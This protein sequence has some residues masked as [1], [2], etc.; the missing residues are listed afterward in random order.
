MHSSEHDAPGI[1][2][3]LSREEVVPFLRVPVDDRR[4]TPIEFP[5]PWPDRPWTF[6]VMVASSNGVVAWRRRGAR[7]DPVRTILG[8]ED[9]PERIA[10]RRLM[11]LLRS[12]GDVAIGAE[13]V[14]EEP[15]LVPT[16]QE[17]GDEPAPELYRFR[18]SRG[19]SYHPRTILYSLYGRLPIAHP[20]FHTPGLQ[21]IVVT[22][23]AGARELA[24]RGVSATPAKLLVEALPD[25]AALARVHRRLH[26][27]LGVRYLACEGGQT[28]LHALHDARL[29]D[30]VFL[31]VTDVVIDD[32]AHED[33]VKIFDFERERAELVAEGRIA[34][35]SRYTFQRWR[36]R[37]R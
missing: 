6:G 27:E 11:R 3:R 4:T 7:D 1:E 18:T 16:P 30:E 13:T 35:D 17:P 29:L 28:V 34:P 15:K 22:T 21:P 31:T 37:S 23:H 12:V 20:V 8:G 26:A 25:P 2:W 19:L 36:F 32:S 14:R 5:P 24:A 9:R 10:D 33:L